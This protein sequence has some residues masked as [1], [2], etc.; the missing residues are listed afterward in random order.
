M[1]AAQRRRGRGHVGPVE[2][3]HLEGHWLVRRRAEHHLRVSRVRA[4]RAVDDQL[5]RGGVHAR[6][7]DGRIVEWT[8]LGRAAAQLQ[9]ERLEPGLVEQ[10]GAVRGR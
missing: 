6:K 1:R 4:A 5:S 10:D 7:G 9:I 3:T 2:A 8:A